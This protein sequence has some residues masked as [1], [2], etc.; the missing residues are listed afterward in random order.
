ML[1]HSQHDA[2]AAEE[3]RPA[4]SLGVQLRRAREA[5]TM[6]LREAAE[7]IH[8]PAQYLTMLESN[9]YSAISDELYLLPFLRAYAEFLELDASIMA[10][11]FLRGIQPMERLA[12]PTP[13]WAMK[14]AG[15]RG[16]W[17]TTAAVMFF[18]ALALYLVL[19]Q[20]GLRP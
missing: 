16:G 15:R 18:V 20:V 2:E 10:A 3:G 7:L 1:T 19:A 5:R 9:D 4:P 11:L 14:P 8:V 12:E 17:F 13:E 6:T